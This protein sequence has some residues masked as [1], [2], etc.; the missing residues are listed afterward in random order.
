MMDLV[1]IFFFAWAFVLMLM[2]SMV[3]GNIIGGILW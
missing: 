2:I 3:L 1:K